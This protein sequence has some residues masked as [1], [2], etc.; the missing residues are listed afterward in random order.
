MAT[1]LVKRVNYLVLLTWSFLYTRAALGEAEVV[2]IAIG[3]RKDFDDITFI[4]Q[5]QKLGIGF[6]VYVLGPLAGSY[7]IYEGIKAFKGTARGSEERNQAMVLLAV[8][9]ALFALGPI[10]SQIIKYLKG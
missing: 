3:D 2:D 10:I 8:G 6:L 7:T 9:A 1:H 4:D 5:I